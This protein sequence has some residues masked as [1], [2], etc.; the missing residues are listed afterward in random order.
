MTTIEECLMKGVV[1]G[2]T[3]SI[4]IDIGGTSIKTALTEEGSV[5]DFRTVETPVDDPR[6]GAAEIHRLISDWMSLADGSIGICAPGPLDTMEGRFLDPPNLPGW[7]GFSLKD[8]LEDKTGRQCLVENDANAA[9]VGEFMYGAGRSFQHIVYVT[10][11][12]GIGAGIVIDGKLLSGAQFQAGEAGNMIIRS[13]G[14]EQ[15]GMNIGSWESLAS[16]TALGIRAEK[17]IGLTGGAAEVFREQASGNQKAAR[18]VSSWIE[19]TACGTANLLHLLNPE[20]VIFGGGVM[21]AAAQ[22]LPELQREV[23]SR[24]YESMRSGV[25]LYAA[26]LKNQAGVIGAAALDHVPRIGAGTSAGRSI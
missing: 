15:P 26:E 14:P 5:L 10:I 21:N 17:E 23:E 6:Q 19:D 2:M 25:Q 13:E 22:I 24:V 16:G 8:E 7:H 9:A 20:A 3:R 11:S 18:L 1:T 12:T 4:G